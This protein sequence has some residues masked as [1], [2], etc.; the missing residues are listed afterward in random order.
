MNIQSILTPFIGAIIGYS[1]NWLAIKMLFRPYTEKRFLGMKVP[2]TPGLI[3]KERHRIANSIGE[4]IE[5]YLLTDT[6]ILDELSKAST[7]EHI[8]QFVNKNLYNEAGNIHLKPLLGSEENQ[9]ILNKLETLLTDKMIDL[10]AEEETRTLLL[11]ALSKQVTLG[12]Q[13]ITPKELVTEE[14]FNHKLQEFMESDR[15]KAI[16][17]GHL[18]KVLHPEQSIRGVVHKEG[19]L[20]IKDVVFYHIEGITSSVD[21]IFENENIKNKVVELIDSTIKEK[22]GALGA[23][24]VNAESIYQTIAQKSKEKLEEEDVKA[25]IRLFVDRKIEEIYDQPL[26]ELLPE[27]GLEQMAR[28]IGTYIQHGAAGLDL[29]AVLPELDKDIYHLIDDVIEDSLEEKIAEMLGKRYDDLLGNGQTKELI[30]HMV[31]AFID[32]T[33][34]SEIAIGEEDKEEIDAFILKKYD[35][36]LERHIMELI[37]EIKLGRIIEEQLNAFDLHML[38]NIILTIAK[39]ELRAITWLGGVLGFII[40]LFTL[41]F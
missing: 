19:L 6:V 4:V 20:Q 27:D 29:Y 36:F 17:D 28:I 41:I 13:G 18:S 3:P 40:G 32:R 14:G 11:D 37:E 39:K 33:L 23:M 7:K 22:V 31:V 24:F 16:L 21:Q 38:E 1:T 30:S 5:E 9:P 15:L 35:G 34:S 26:G 8:L 12:L 2:F 25:N 10:M